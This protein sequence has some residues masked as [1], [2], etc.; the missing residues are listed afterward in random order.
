MKAIYLIG[1]MGAGKTSVSR[2]LAEAL[3]VTHYDT[4]QEIVKAAGKSISDIFAGEGEERFRDMES[5]VLKM[6]PKHDA[7][8]ATGGGIVLAEQNRHHMKSN[9]TVIF[10][11]ADIE[12]ILQRLEGDDSR[13]LLQ[14]DK[15][16][17]AQSLYSS[18]LPIYRQTAQ[19]E[20]NTNSKTVTDIVKEI[21][22][23]MK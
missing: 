21:V 6:M 7:V 20:I 11:Y 17:A 5:D 16:Y 8:I 13:P 15:L 4:D 10:L 12:S 18:R 14:N 19:L 1:F 23:S 3:S 9:G 22:G 2:K